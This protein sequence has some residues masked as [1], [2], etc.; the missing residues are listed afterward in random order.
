MELVKVVD[1]N[2]KGLTIKVD[3]KA[4]KLVKEEYAAQVEYLLEALVGE[5]EE[6]GLQYSISTEG[7]EIILE[8]K[9]AKP[10]YNVHI[11]VEFGKETT[12]IGIGKYDIIKDED[13]PIFTFMF[14]E[15]VLV[16][17]FNSNDI[18]L[19][20]FDGKTKYYATIPRLEEIIVKID[21]KDQFIAVQIN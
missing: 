20:T 6:K 1:N 2:E 17:I 4:K 3:E 15:P 14:A 5:F 16:K 18:S 7:F 9:P 13:V 19:T 21:L 11:T 10:E 8:A 12:Y